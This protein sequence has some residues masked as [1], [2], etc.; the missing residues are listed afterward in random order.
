MAAADRGHGVDRLDARLQRLA[1][2]LPFGHARRHEFDRAALAGDDRT[3]AIQRVA[4]RIDDAAD[5]G[6]THRYAQQATG[7]FDFVPFV[8]R[9]EVAQ[10]DHTDR[11]LFEVEGQ[12]VDAAGKLDHLAGHHAR[13]S[14]DARNA[15]ADLQHA[16]DL[17]DVDLR[18]VLLN[19]LLDYGSDLVRL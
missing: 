5:H 13:Q 8:D 4:E 16:P 14:I 6:V 9:E 7:A 12:A 1:H 3:L 10:D 17:A 19:F 2:R 15:V 18:F 11:V